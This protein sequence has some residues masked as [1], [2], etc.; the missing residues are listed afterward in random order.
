MLKEYL[1]VDGYNI[2]NAWAD[3]KEESMLSLEAAR[4][5]LVDKM[6]EYQAYKD[7]IVIVV[8]DA[9]YVKN[10]Q[11]KHEFYH[12][13]EV[14]YT[15]EFESA[16]GYIER[17]IAS[18]PIDYNVKVATSDWAEQLLILGLG[19]SRVSARELKEEVSEMKKNMDKEFINKNSYN[20]N[21]LEHSLDP[22]ILT[23]LEKLR[24]NNDKA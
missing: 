21:L 13:V 15:K 20:K 11:E 1:V 24:R 4:F 17:Y 8:F 12:G 6:S 18:I 19:A 3:L 14:V 16:D 22:N 2:I 10:S 7:I 9:H 23:K 5:K